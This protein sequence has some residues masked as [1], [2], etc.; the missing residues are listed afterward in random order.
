MGN[1][2]VIF[3]TK[4]LAVRAL[5]D[6]QLLGSQFSFS[7]FVPSRRELEIQIAKLERMLDA[8]VKK[9]GPEAAALK[10]PAERKAFRRKIG[11]EIAKQDRQAKKM[12]GLFYKTLEESYFQV[13]RPDTRRQFRQALVAVSRN[14]EK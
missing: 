3:R 11:P 5:M 1:N 4:A 13:P 10:T 12:Q 14:F 2:L 6:G 9:F 8:F 7:G